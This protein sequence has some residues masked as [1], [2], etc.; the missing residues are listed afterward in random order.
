MYVRPHKWVK[1]NSMMRLKTV[2]S[3][4]L[5]KGSQYHIEKRINVFLP[6][7]NSSI[8]FIGLEILFLYLQET[9]QKLDTPLCKPITK[10]INN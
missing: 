4:Y 2:F 3:H 6:G 9:D 5:S 7:K 1:V 8:Q 10:P